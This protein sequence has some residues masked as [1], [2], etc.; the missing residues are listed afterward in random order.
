M[1]GWKNREL[2]TLY[3]DRTTLQQ[4]EIDFLIRESAMKDL[5]EF[6]DTEAGVDED[7][8]SGEK[9][10]CEAFSLVCAMEESQG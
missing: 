7:R 2:S 9:E 3:D 1:S 10:R 5:T 6:C 8:Q 4:H